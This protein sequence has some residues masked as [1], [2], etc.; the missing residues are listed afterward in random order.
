MGERGHS[1]H[2]LDGQGQDRLASFGHRL[3]IL[4]FN[5]RWTTFVPM[6]QEPF[7]DAE[8]SR[9]LERPVLHVWFDDDCGVAIQ[10]YASGALLGE[11]SLPCEEI[12]SSDLSF[13]AKLEEVDVLTTA[14]RATLLERM[15]DDEQA[16]DWTMG[17]GVERLLNLPFFDP[18]PLGLPEGATLAS[19][20]DG[21]RAR[22]HEGTK[23]GP[24]WGSNQA[25]LPDGGGREG[26]LD[27]PG[28]ADALPSLRV[29]VGGL[30][31]EQLPPLQPVQEA[32]ARQPATRR[33]SPLRCSG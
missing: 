24:W 5:E 7:D 16:W 12:S 1:I 25:P 20:Q 22:T 28:G 13:I 32:P 9:V 11:L 4:G 17:H 3:A 23:A 14:Q 2:V 10:V 19:T 18:M 6:G 15:A 29:L 26:G 27:G 33:G 8:A 21:H 31:P 30:E